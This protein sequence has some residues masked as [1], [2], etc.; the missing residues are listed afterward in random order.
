MNKLHWKTFF[1]SLL[2]LAA[3]PLFAQS[4]VPK[5]MQSLTDSI[6][7][8]LNGPLVISICGIA[9]IAS[10]IAFVVNKDNDRLKKGLFALFI[11]VVIIVG[12]TQIVG[13]VWA[14]SR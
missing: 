7:E 3:T 6:L 5:G 2:L 14:A 8:A 10:G 9:L 13:A 11:G 4:I 1:F 12:A